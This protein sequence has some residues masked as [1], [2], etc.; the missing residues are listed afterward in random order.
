LGLTFTMTPNGAAALA[1]Q[2]AAPPRKMYVW[3]VNGSI[4][5]RP[6]MV[7]PQGMKWNMFI[8]LQQ[9]EEIFNELTTKS[10]KP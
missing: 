4:V 3:V 5:T 8:G 9:G 10:T 7:A 1:Q 2:A 6:R